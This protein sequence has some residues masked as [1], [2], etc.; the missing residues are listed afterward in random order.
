MKSRIIKLGPGECPDAETGARYFAALAFPG[1][2]EEQARHDA[3]RG[4]VGAYLHEAN[5]VDENT[6][7]FMDDRLN[8]FVQLEPKWCEAKIR[9]GRRRLRDRSNA[10]RTVRPWV[11]ELLGQPHRPIEGIDKF[12]QRQIAL[13]L[14]HGDLEGASNFLKRVWRPSRPVLHLSIAYDFTLSAL[15]EDRDVY[16]VN[17]ASAP[18]FLELVA[19]AKRVLPL[20]C[21]DPRFKISESDLLRLEWVP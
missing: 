19:C 6:A 16:E 14:K 4:W 13:F 7:P 15:G 8:Q 17:L 9:T 20:I 10:A 12:N 11:N 1:V 2:G 18:L 21:K 3:V 5:R